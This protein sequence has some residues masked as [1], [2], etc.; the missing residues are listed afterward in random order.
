[1]ND[2]NE[3]WYLLESEPYATLR[4]GLKEELTPDD[5]KRK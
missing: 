5:I 1:M 4:C 3:M 2:K